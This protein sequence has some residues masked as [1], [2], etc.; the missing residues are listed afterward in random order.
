MRMLAGMAEIKASSFFFP[1]IL[2][3]P[4]CHTDF[5]PGGCNA[6]SMIEKKERGVHDR[7]KRKKRKKKE[8]DADNKLIIIFIYIYINIYKYI[9]IKKNTISIFKNG[10]NK[11]NSTI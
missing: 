4:Q 9:S 10:F 11:H 1:S 7:K 6:L 2:R 5:Q 3:I 8:R